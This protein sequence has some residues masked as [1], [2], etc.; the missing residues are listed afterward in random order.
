MKKIVAI[1]ALAAVI[2]A[3]TALA[4]H[5]GKK[6][7]ADIDA[8]ANGAITLTEL[9]ALKPEVTAEKFAKYDTDASGG[10]SEAEME[11]WKAKKAAKAAQDAA[12][13][14]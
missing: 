2:A 3:P 13:A 8:D 1:A 14:E 11:A 12:K 4:D 6:T 7:F 5:H 9:Q 10:L